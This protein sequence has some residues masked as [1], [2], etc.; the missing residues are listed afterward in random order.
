MAFLTLDSFRNRRKRCSHLGLEGRTEEDLDFSRIFSFPRFCP[1]IPQMLV[2][3]MKED[4]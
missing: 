4:V 3:A 2:W 1:G